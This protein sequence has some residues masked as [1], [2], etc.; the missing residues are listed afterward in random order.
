MENFN[1]WE[2]LTAVFAAVSAYLVGHNRGSQK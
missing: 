1:W 2:L